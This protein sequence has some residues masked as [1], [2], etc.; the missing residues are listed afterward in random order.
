MDFTLYIYIYTSS[1][2]GDYL[3][4]AAPVNDVSHPAYCFVLLR[5]WSLRRNARP[6]GTGITYRLATCTAETLRTPTVSSSWSCP[7]VTCARCTTPSSA[8]PHRS[9]PGWCTTIIRSRTTT[10]PRPVTYSS[11]STAARRLGAPS[12]S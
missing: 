2:K 6:R 11:T 1:G 10:T 4:R 8:C 7:S 3:A 9:R 12:A 5:R